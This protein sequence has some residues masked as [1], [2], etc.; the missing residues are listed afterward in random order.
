MSCF[1]S[2]SQAVMAGLDPAIQDQFSCLQ[3]AAWMPGSR[4]GMTAH[5]AGKIG[6]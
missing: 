3:G 5:L 4:P 1:A 6:S 2:P